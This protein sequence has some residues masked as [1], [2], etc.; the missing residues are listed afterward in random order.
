MAYQDGTCLHYGIGGDVG[1]D[2]AAKYY[3][4]AAAGD[5]SA[6]LPHSFRCRRRRSTDSCDDYYYECGM[7][8]LGVLEKYRTLRPFASE[9]GMW[10]DLVE[11]CFPES[12]V[13]VASGGSSTVTLS[14]DPIS[15]RKTAIK[16][17]YSKNFEKS[18]FIR[19]VELLVGL[20]H[21]CV[22]R[23]VG[24]SLPT[25]SPYA[26]IHTDYAENGS[27]TCVLERAR[28]GSGPHFL[29]PTGK[30][31]IICGIVLGMRYVHSRGLIHRDLKPGDIFVNGDRPTLISDFGT[32][33]FELDDATLM[34]DTGT[35]QYAPPELFQDR[36]PYTTKV[37]VFSL[38]SVIY[39]IILGF[40]VFKVSFTG[41]ENSTGW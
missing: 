25:D 24:Y 11:P 16:R 33:R 29:N 7:M 41:H 34:P 28:F 18:Q 38:G 19:E 27:L 37:D 36:I 1:L 12:E 3:E 14:I 9:K 4:L 22:L 40:P 13:L 8:R 20:N 15:G 23:I 32:S 2:E 21:P 5:R 17:I 31:I 39:E 26:E 6:I 35:I 30:V 10:N